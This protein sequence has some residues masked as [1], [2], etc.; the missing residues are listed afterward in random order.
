MGDY[1]RSMNIN[2]L[3]KKDHYGIRSL[4]Q[5]AVL[6]GIRL[7]IASEVEG[8][9]RLNEATVKRLTGGNTLTAA[10]LHQSQFVFTPQFKIWMLVNSLPM[11]E[12]VSHGFWRRVCVVPFNARF[13][14]KQRQIDIKTL[15]LKERNGILKWLIEGAKK[16]HAEH[17]RLGGSGLA[18][19]EAVRDA[20]DTYK[21]KCDPVK[22]YI[23]A[24]TTKS[25]G[26]ETSAQILFDA[27]Q[28]WCRDGY[29]ISPV[30][31]TVFSKLLVSNGFERKRKR[32]GYVYLGLKLK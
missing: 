21:D 27:Y 4:E 23:A 28:V 32:D 7:S 11:S 13:E 31:Q 29:G 3:M 19:C 6:D 14:G 24:C 1:A 5:I 26:A 16:W 10:R 20:T 12:D 25:S 8:G 22:M 9:G 30:T 18:F 17:K 15:L 2:E